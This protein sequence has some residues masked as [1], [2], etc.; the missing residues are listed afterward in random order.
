MVTEKQMKNLKPLNERSQRD[1]KEIAKMGAE[2]SNKAQALDKMIARIVESM[3]KHK[4]TEQEKSMLQKV[5]P[6]LPAQDV[7]KS[8]MVIASLWNQA[9]IRGNTKAAEMILKLMGALK[10][11]REISGNIVTQKVF[12]TQGQQQSVEKHIE[13]VLADDG[14]SE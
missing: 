8:S 2:A 14:K 10:D 9:V 13:E 11:Q 3:A 1:R 6:E 4:A 12:V 5:F 7:N